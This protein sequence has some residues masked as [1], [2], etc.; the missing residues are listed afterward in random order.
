LEI[1]Q[2]FQ[3]PQIVEYLIKYDMNKTTQKKIAFYILY[4]AR[5]ET[6]QEYVPTWKFVGEF[7]IKEWGEWVMASYK[8]PT[9][10]TDIYQENPMLL[11]RR[12]VKGKSGA[13]YYEYRIANSAVPS[14]IK[15]ETLLG[16]YKR[17]KRG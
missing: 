5:Q 17:L 13:R 14:D 2:D 9:R 11:E 10:L 16:M 1:Y 15:D 8:C 6:P 3:L 12:Q 7:L 4:K